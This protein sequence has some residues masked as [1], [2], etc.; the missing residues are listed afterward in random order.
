MRI[1]PIKNKDF[2]FGIHT[3]NYVDNKI[4]VDGLVRRFSPILQFKKGIT[5]NKRIQLNSLD[6]K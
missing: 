2:N 3:I 6:D 1:F 5:K 4:V